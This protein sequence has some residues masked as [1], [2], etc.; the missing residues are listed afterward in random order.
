MTSQP[1]LPGL[2][3]PKPA[4]HQGPVAQ[5][6][7]DLPA[8]HLDQVFDYALPEPLA[9]RAEVGQ[10]ITARFGSRDRSGFIVGISDG[11]AHAGQ[12]RDLRS[13][14]SD[15]PVLTAEVTQVIE[16]I[17]THYAGTFPDVARL[18]IPPRHARTEQAVCAHVGAPLTVAPPR[19][20]GSELF[21]AYEGGVR[22]LERIA[23]GANPTAVIDLLPGVL[24]DR[25]RWFY[26]VLELVISALASA[27]RALV[28][29][30][31]ARHVAT[32][33]AA[34]TEAGIRAIDYQSSQTP[35][36]RY[37]AF[38]LALLGQVDVVVGTRSAVW[39][40]LPNLGLTIVVDEADPL[41]RERHAPRPHVWRIAVARAGATALVSMARS[42][43]AHLL[44]HRGE[45]ESYAPTRAAQRALGPR[46]LVG[47]PRSGPP[48]RLPSQA[49]RLLREGLETG[50]V[51]VIVPR[52]G[53][54]QAVRCERCRALARCPECGGP[55]QAS[56][57]ARLRCAWA[58]HL[59]TRWSCPLCESAAWRAGTIGSERTAEELGR[60]F[61]GVLIRLSGART[62]IVEKIS[63]KP[64]IVVATLGAVPL[65]D[66]GYRCAVLL[67]GAALTA[68]TELSA[69]SQVMSQLSWAAAL[70][71]PGG[72]GGRMVLTGHLDEPL[73][74]ALIRA[75]GAGYAER[76]LAERAQ[77]HLPPVATVAEFTA[78]R[79]ALTQVARDL[80]E[81]TPG[82][83]VLGPVALDEH[84]DRLLVR[85][86]PAGAAAL[87]REVATVL[88]RRSARG[89][90]P[91][92]ATMDPEDL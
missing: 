38:L 68:R 43:Q 75:D 27:R 31:A 53:Y 83:E 88:R 2:A 5:V 37:R 84:T 82:T 59:I 21:R 39:A 65:A 91:I 85:V 11:T 13:L 1:E 78:P 34:L 80:A 66:G 79:S 73:A 44:V 17:A 33:V 46:V 20:P 50:P 81:V 47:D 48:Q 19:P 62:G 15:L 52:G 8:A 69:P 12:L 57:P 30:P 89:E 49:F 29:V 63:A 41:L 6:R 42:P 51:L 3:L 54:I 86:P 4:T 87:R 35:A 23:A 56:A 77:L 32:M 16:D 36:K 7:L 28:V 26:Q 58:D 10:R 61:P 22:L 67:D 18:A 14:V 55:V 72:D 71:A 70:V 9:V 45:A 25:P 64:A 24:G 40:P 74:Q 92:S 76:L 60:A 90:T